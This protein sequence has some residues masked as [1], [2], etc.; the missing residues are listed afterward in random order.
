MNSEDTSKANPKSYVNDDDGL[1]V[2]SAVLDLEDQRDFSRQ[3]GCC[4]LDAKSKKN[5]TRITD[6]RV[7]D[8][9]HEVNDHIDK[10]HSKLGFHPGV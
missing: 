6:E 10:R 4:V 3:N 1:L 5:K 2:I 7:N 8:T 9:K